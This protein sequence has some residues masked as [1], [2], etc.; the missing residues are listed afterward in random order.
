MKLASKH[1][2]R[3]LA[4][5]FVGSSIRWHFTLEVRPPSA[6]GKHKG[7]TT[8]DGCIA[9]ADCDRTVKWQFYDPEPE[10][11]LGKIDNA[12]AELQA[13]RHALAQI[14][15]EEAKAR[16]KHKIPKSDND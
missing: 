4:P 12:I 16:R 9:L 6:D 2:S 1:G 14:V 13:A 8:I 5:E 11:G 15:T 10:E 7:S 3:F